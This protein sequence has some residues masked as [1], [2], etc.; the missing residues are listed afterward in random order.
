[1][2]HK[3]NISKKGSLGKVRP[4]AYI[5]CLFKIIFIKINGLQKDHLFCYVPGYLM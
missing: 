5:Q 3:F 2:H 4:V 1:V